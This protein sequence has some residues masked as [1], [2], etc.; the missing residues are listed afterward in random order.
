MYDAMMER[1]GFGQGQTVLKAATQLREEIC[2]P[3]TQKVHVT[4]LEA[5]TDEQ[6]EAKH[7]ALQQRLASETKERTG[8][9]V[10]PRDSSQHCVPGC[11]FRAGHEG[12]HYDAVNDCYV[13]R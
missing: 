12:S 5:L 1:T 10:V 6:L 7:L 4:G 8:R 11:D 3:L 2:G 13:E 9:I